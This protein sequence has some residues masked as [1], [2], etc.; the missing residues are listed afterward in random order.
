MKEPAGITEE[1]NYRLKVKY[2]VDI[3]NKEENI[4]LQ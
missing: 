3:V 1:N 4:K 2:C